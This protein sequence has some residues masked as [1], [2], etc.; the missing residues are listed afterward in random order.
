LPP[1]MQDEVLRRM[2]DRMHDGPEG[3]RPGPRR[4]PE[5]QGRDRRPERGG[6]RRPAPP[7]DEVPMPPPERPD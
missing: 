2:E 7:M 1:D 5:G 4:R 3:D 6:E